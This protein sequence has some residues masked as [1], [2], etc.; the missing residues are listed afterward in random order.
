MSQPEAAGPMAVKIAAKHYQALCGLA[1]AAILLLQFQQSA[2]A[3]FAPGLILFIHALTLFIGVAGILYRIRMT[4]AVVLLTVAAPKVIE[5]YYQSQVAFVDVRGVRVFDVADMLMCVAGLIFFIGYYRLQG[6]WFGVLPPDPRRHGKPA[7]PPM[8]RS[9]DS[10]RPAELL[11]LI[12]VVPIFV[13]LAELSFVVLNQPWNLLELDYRWNQFLLV[14]WA[15]LLTMFLG[16]HA[17]RYWR[18]L[19]MNRMTAL[20]MLQDI[21][22][23]ETRGEQRKI[24][25]WLAWR[26]LRNKAR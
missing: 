7:R 1:L 9:E 17:F 18:R 25:R 15:I 13:I 26:R 8:V 23:H 24:Q 2:Q 3:V 14:S 10:M 20:V 12:L 6:L 21:L 19:N 4:P 11:S 22:W 16:A 5:R